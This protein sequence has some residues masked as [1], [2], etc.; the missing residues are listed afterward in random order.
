[1]A[2]H[3]RAGCGG[4]RP[5]PSGCSTGHG[6]CGAGELSS[7]GNKES[8]A[9][10]GAEGIRAASLHTPVVQPRSRCPPAP[11]VAPRPAARGAEA[12]G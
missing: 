11:Q 4:V 8:T 7:P 1:M 12:E 10:A 2:G 3:H 5:V 6:G 9:A